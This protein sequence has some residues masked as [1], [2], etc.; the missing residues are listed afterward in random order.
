MTNKTENTK[1]G[2]IAASFT[3][4]ILLGVIL[5]AVNYISSFAIFR[6]D[7][8]AE[9]LFTLSAGTKS[10][11]TKLADKTKLKFY[12]SKSVGN[13]P[14]HYKLYG[15]RVEEFLG[16]YVENNP[17]MLELEVLDPQPDTDVE[18][19]AVK[20]GLA[21]AG[22][23]T[24]QKFYFGLVAISADK[25]EIIPFFSLDREEFLEYD[26]T[27]AIVQASNPEKATIGI[28]STLPVLA[29]QG[30]PFQTSPQRAQD[31]LFIKELKKNF[32]VKPV[33]INV[34]QIDQKIDLL[35]VIHPKKLP[36][37]TAYAIDQ[38]ILKGGRA[39]IL[40]DPFSLADNQQPQ[41]NP[42]MAMMNRSSN[43][44]KLFKAW[45]IEYNPQQLAADM[46]LATQLNFGRQGLVK[47]PLWMSLRGNSFNKESTI[48]AK[49]N[50]MMLVNAGVLKKAKDSKFE[51]TSLLKT[52][53]KGSEINTL[54]A[55]GPVDAINRELTG[56]GEAKTLAAIIRGELTSAFTQAPEPKA[57]EKETEEA[58]KVR[59]ARHEAMKKNHVSKAK[60]PVSVMVIADT[61]FLQNDYSVKAMNIFGRIL[62]Q[63]LNHNLAFISNCADLLA[64]SADL[65]A[66]RS[67]NR[68]SRTFTKVE[69]IER[70]AQQ[71]WQQEEITLTKKLEEIQARINNLQSQKKGGER[72]ILSAQ[73]RDEIMKA[74][75]EKSDTMRKRREIRKLLRQDI[76]NLGI[77][78]TF[79][80]LLF[81]PLIIIII[82]TFLYYRKNSR[83]AM[84]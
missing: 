37:T 14:F 41:N 74:R 13:V 70:A 16:E 55:M 34:S 60:E 52:S 82:G 10:V 40:A 19:W 43:L 54:K 79:A 29:P 69:E 4:I 7:L 58:K 84:I 32:N 46:T 1:R 71:K 17:G 38:F 80:N 44:P 36:E 81:M 51:F 45:G 57:P 11:L 33:D 61:D 42:Y 56:S 31:W 22:L 15:K 47:H 66:V 53:D 68:S 26:I 20:Y 18:E 65:I 67:R 48:S 59:L 12:F 21:A 72:L 3:S 24:G 27:R 25:E 35:M 6:A 39:I 73:Q 50:I 83:R 30:M 63:P 75:K 64:G 8:T 78:V 62:L 5:A 9:K 77:K 2:G 76:E 49:L 28:L 23:P